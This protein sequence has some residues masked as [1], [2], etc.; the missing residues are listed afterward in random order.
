[1]TRAQQLPHENLPLIWP[2][3]SALF[4]VITFIAALY[5]WFGGAFQ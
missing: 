3:A 1:M 5:V 4:V 2:T